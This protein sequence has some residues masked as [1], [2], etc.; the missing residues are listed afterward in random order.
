[1][2]LAI[3]CVGMLIGSSVRNVEGEFRCSKDDAGSYNWRAKYF[4]T[5]VFSKT[6]LRICMIAAHAYIL[7]RRLRL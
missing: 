4:S 1:M 2:K 3:E 5:F 7:L 6:I